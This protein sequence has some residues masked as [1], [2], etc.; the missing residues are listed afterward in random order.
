MR[1][2]KDTV[3]LPAAE[4]KNKKKISQRFAPW[5]KTD[6][7]AALFFCCPSLSIRWL[8][9][10]EIKNPGTEIKIGNKSIGIKTKNPE[11]IFNRINITAMQKYAKQDII[12][13]LNFW[14]F[15]IMIG[16]SICKPEYPKII[17]LIQSSD[18]LL[19]IN[20]KI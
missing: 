3:L 12:P 19:S 9:I 6:K 5:F 10:F 20:F 17:K 1:K 16:F 7:N 13:G 18:M 8:V 11:R 15:F 4:A 2:I 14:S